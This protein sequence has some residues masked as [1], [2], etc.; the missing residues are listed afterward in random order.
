MGVGVG[1]TTEDIARDH[2]HLAPNKTSDAAQPKPTYTCAG[3]HEDLETARK[4]PAPP[5]DEERVL[6][7]TAS[8]HGNFMLALAKVLRETHTSLKGPQKSKVM[9]YVWSKM[10]AQDQAAWAPP[11]RARRA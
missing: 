9:G 8:P 4:I 5:T 7:P 6:L 1:M 10:Q 2:P 11:A 3:V